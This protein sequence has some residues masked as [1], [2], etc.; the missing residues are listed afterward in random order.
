MYD[1]YF[2]LL[3]IL[4]ILACLGDGYT[5]MM[6]ITAGKLSE[7][8]PVARWLFSK[9]GESL[10]VFLGTTLFIF[11]SVLIYGF[12]KPQWIGW[13]YTGAL[14]GLETFNTIRNYRLDK[15]TKAL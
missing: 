5:T 9:I 8:N 12:I 13:T 7:S 2:F 11:S 14:T 3:V 6:G 4:G 1:F 10:T 15:E